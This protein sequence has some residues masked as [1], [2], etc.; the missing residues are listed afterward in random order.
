MVPFCDEKFSSLKFG[1][2]NTFCCNEDKFYR[3]IKIMASEVDE[4]VT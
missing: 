1:T 4:K 3:Q 2:E